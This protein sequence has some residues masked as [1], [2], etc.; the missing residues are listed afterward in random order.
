MAFGQELRSLRRHRHNAGNSGA[1]RYRVCEGELRVFCSIR[2]CVEAAQ[3][4][5]DY[6]GRR[7]SPVRND[8]I[9]GFLEFR[10]LAVD[11]LRVHEV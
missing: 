9:V 4:G 11:K 7:K 6:R 1:R 8:G 10:E 5:L 3:D 2:S